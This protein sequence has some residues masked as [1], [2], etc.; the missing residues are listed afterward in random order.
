MCK[1]M[2]YKVCGDG[3]QENKEER[4]VKRRKRFML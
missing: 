2:F 4:G 1:T 3:E